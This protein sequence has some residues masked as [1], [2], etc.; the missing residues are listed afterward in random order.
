LTSS[1]KIQ[2]SKLA[3]WA[4]A[5][6]V[7]YHLGNAVG[8]V[9]QMKGLGVGAGSSVPK[10]RW[11]VETPR[12]DSSARFLEAAGYTIRYWLGQENNFYYFG[13]SRP[14]QRLYVRMDTGVMDS[15][16]DEKN[17][18]Y[19]KYVDHLFKEATCHGLRP[20]AV[21]VP[22]K[23]AVERERLPA[24]LPLPKQWKPDSG[25]KEETQAGRR[26]L[27]GRKAN[28]WLDLYETFR[29]ANQ[30]DEVYV[31]WDYHLTSYG[32]SVVTAELVKRLNAEGETLGEPQ[33]VRT[34]TRE[35][36]YSDVLIGMLKLP[37]WILARPEF[38][39]KEPFY[40]VRTPGRMRHWKRVVLAGTSFTDR[41]DRE[42]LGLASLIER[43][44][45]VPVRR[46]TANGSTADT[47]L[48]KLVKEGV[49]LE[50]GDIF[51]LEQPL[52]HFLREASVYP[53]PWAEERR[54]SS[55]NP[56]CS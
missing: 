32:L 25:W 50:A 44:L 16:L 55:E 45:H 28:Q 12:F 43:A 52:D 21:F 24:R 34:G 54:I 42:K 1:P 17:L 51:V 30:K 33:I 31:P 14:L 10:I 46:A 3:R 23:S 38:Q 27:A 35:A 56:D 22:P 26:I 5:A 40:E 18:T 29:Q 49:K 8:L 48:N 47:I 4:F 7:L 20:F 11:A 41:L 6:V 13:P 15:N 9:R 2:Q 19:P 53:S 37:D 36:Y 39:W